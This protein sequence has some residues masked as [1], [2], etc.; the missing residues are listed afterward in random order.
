MNKPNN[1]VPLY[2][3]KQLA[4]LLAELEELKDD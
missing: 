1:Y 2:L 4:K 3:E